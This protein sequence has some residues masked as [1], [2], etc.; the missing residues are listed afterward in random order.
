MRKLVLAS[1]NKGKLKELQEMLAGLPLIVVGLENFPGAPEVEETGKTFEENAVIKAKTIAAFTNELTLADDSGLEV[2]S[3]GGEP[4]VYS[5][6]YGEPGWNDR[7]RYEY[8]LQKLAN[9]PAGSRQ[10]RFRSVVALYD[11]LVGSLEL[12]SG[13]V[14]GEIINEPRGNNGFGYDPVFF[15]PGYRRT[16]A[17]LSAEEKNATSHRARAV[18]RMIPKIR[19]VLEAR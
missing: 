7:Q 19:R 6:R 12:A 2:D 4:G 3:L 8:L 14:E 13:A 18:M 17:E 16:M 11:P 1:R 5:A 10:A 9:V 15:L